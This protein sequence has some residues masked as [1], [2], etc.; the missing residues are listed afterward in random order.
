MPRRSRTSR[1]F[2]STSSGGRFPQGLAG[3]R[4]PPALPVRQ[5]HRVPPDLR[6]RFRQRFP[7]GQTV[8]GWYYAGGSASAGFDLAVTEMAFV[9]PPRGRADRSLHHVRRPDSSGLYGRREQSGRKRWASMRL[10]AKLDQRGRSQ[11]QRSWRR[12]ND[13]QMGRRN[14]HSLCGRQHVLHKGCL[15]GDRL[16]TQQSGPASQQGAGPDS[17]RR[18]L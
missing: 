2:G 4:V 10:R 3:R 17:R 11:Y 14:L 5:A 7:A 18:V 15:G 9:H 13:D 6:D 1:C 16:V 12:W 8:R